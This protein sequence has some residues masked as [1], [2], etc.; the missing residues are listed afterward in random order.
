MPSATVVCKHR[1]INFAGHAQNKPVANAAI[2]RSRATALW[3]KAAG[4]A[5]PQSCHGPAE[6]L[7]R[8]DFLQ[9]KKCQNMLVA[10]SGE[11]LCKKPGAAMQLL[12]KEECVWKEECL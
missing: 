3:Q 2:P 5:A 6:R 12:K 10:V 8:T 9:A 11:V 1:G 4:T 7:N